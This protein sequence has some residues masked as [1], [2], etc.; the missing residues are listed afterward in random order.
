MLTFER[1]ALK[2]AAFRLRESRMVVQ[3]LRAFG[4]DRIPSSAIRMIRQR[5]GTALLSR[6]LK[7][8]K[9]ATGWVYAA[10]QEAAKQNPD[11]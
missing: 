1:A 3:A 7:D 8:T 6:V 11:V 4:E 2:E 10:I 5:F 9:Y